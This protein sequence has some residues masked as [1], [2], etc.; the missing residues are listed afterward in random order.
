MFVDVYESAEGGK[1]A[2]WIA[3]SGVIDL[4]LLPGA[5]GPK[6]FY[7]QYTSITG[8]PALPPMFSLGY[9][10]CRWNYKDE[11]DVAMVHGECS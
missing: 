4:F 6:E 2:H 5:V 8:T 1:G 10:Q 9:H 7:R 11:K 3:E